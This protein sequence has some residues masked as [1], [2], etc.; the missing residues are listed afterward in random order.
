MSG[1][2]DLSKI[3]NRINAL[4]DPLISSMKAID[5]SA[6]ASIGKTISES[7]ASIKVYQQPFMDESL[8]SAVNKM[9]S[10]ML[11]L[12]VEAM[13]VDFSESV[14]SLLESIRPTIDMINANPALFKNNYD[15]MFRGFFELGYSVSS[16][17]EQAYEEAEEGA[18]DDFK[19]DKEIIEALQEQEMDPVGFQ[20]RIAN[21]SEKKK[22]KYYIVLLILG[23]IW[24]NFI[25]PCFQDSIGK[26]VV[27]YTI[28]KVRKFPEIASNVIDELGEGVEGFITEDVP[29]YYKVTYTDENGEEREGYVAKKNLKVIE[30]PEEEGTTGD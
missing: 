24:A 7:A 2:D 22:K 23:F 3:A 25:A 10:A 18:S 29:Y 6:V 26:P 17:A 30:E 19:T 21:W 8:M 12:P 11:A 20:E 16:L 1:Y 13:N 9:R 5:M 14:Q 28:S 27:A 4:Y 15:E